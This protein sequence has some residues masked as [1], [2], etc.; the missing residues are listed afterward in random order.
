MADPLLAE[1]RAIRPAPELAT[2]WEGFGDPDLSRIVERA[3]NANLDIAA[4]RA[5]LDR[6]AAAVK[7]ARAEQLPS[8]GLQGQ[9]AVQRQ[10]LE[11]QLGP[12]VELAP[13][14]ERT[15]DSYSVGASASWEVDLFGGAR[16]GREAAS[17]DA[18]AAYADLAAARITVI[19]EAADAYI[20]LR[21]LQQRRVLLGEQIAAAA[22]LDR[23]ARGRV[24]AGLAAS[25]DSRRTAAQ[26][27][28]L[29]AG[30][31]MLEA[32][33]TAQLNRLDVLM[34]A[35]PGTYRAE[36]A[37]VRPVPTP[38]AFANTGGAGDLLRRRP[39]L[40]AGERRLAASSARIG[41][42]IA[43][44]Y[45]KISL[46]GLLG[47]EAL[48]PERLL[49]G[50]ALTAS[51]AGGLRW[52]LFDFGRVD[53]QV[54][55]ARGAEREALASYRQ[56]VLRAVEEV[57]TGIVALVQREAQARKLAQAE[58]DLTSAR[59]SARAAYRA[60]VQRLD[61][62]LDVERQLLAVRDERAQAQAESARAT[63]SVFRALGGGW[64]AEDRTARAG[65]APVPPSGASQD[66]SGLPSV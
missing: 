46:S 14:F 56:L 63:V 42:A 12:L 40:L 28:Q 24:S 59:N 39:D 9:A 32:A 5:R 8:V 2:W 66:H 30:L 16:R 50:N 10:S 48:D 29:E 47:F 4:A 37:V 55:D 23:L 53:A 35:K 58:G 44:Y 33:A 1:R 45:P 7:L 49:T 52:R 25:Q 61:E 18:Q 21:L 15:F 27:R 13:G 43:E 11:G 64:T 34:G 19:A 6:A 51:L 65:A 26:L 54:A 36:L 22:S 20:Q 62:T 17:A 3:A 57:E 31:P 41:R 38:P 60:G